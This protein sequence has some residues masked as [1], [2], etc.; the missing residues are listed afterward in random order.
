MII[1]ISVAISNGKDIYFL[2]RDLYF[3]YFLN[4]LFIYVTEKRE[5]TSWG[6]SRQRE[7]QREKQAPCRE[8]DVGLEPRSPGSGPGPKV[9]LNR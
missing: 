6:D 2:K 1:N 3:Y 9:V 4:I 7:R 8:P 5:C